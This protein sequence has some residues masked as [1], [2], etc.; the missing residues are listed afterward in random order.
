MTIEDAVAGIAATITGRGLKCTAVRDDGSYPGKVKVSDTR[1]RWLEE[2]VIV[3]HGPHRDLNYTIL[4]APRSA[5]EPEPGPDPGP[6]RP[7]RVPAAVLNHPALT[8]ITAEAL[9]ALTAVL[10]VPFGA[11]RE[12]RNYAIRARRRGT[13]TRARAPRNGGPDASAG[14][15]LADHILATR[16][17]DHLGLPHAPIG[18]LLGVD[19]TTISRAITL[20][21]GLLADERIPLPPGTPPPETIPSTPGELL[22]H[23]AAAGI[24]L[25]LPENGKTMPERF[26]AHR[27]PST[28]TRSKPT[29]K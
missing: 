13:G 7:G 22:A 2:R 25:T 24:P 5:P 29:T 17:R 12:Q 26:K 21:R 28:A 15:T 3:R 19:G 11:R 8:G 1:M 10:E 16:L 9:N 18:V 14:L 20:T 27:Y 4:P 6:G 23:A